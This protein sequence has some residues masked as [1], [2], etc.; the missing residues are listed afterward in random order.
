MSNTATHFI[1]SYTCWGHAYCF[2]N[3]DEQD[4][5]MDCLIRKRDLAPCLLHSDAT[6]NVFF[7][8]AHIV[9]ESDELGIPLC[10]SGFLILLIRNM[11]R[12][13]CFYG[14]FFMFFF[15]VVPHS[16]A[17]RSAL[18]CPDSPNCC[19]RPERRVKS[20]SQGMCFI[21]SC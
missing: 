10:L 13:L 7:F 6:P 18:S 11:R 2:L 9:S 15:F 21:P 3:S 19:A 4:Y 5:G 8:F 14:V 1:A 16:C 20:T 17:A 12:S